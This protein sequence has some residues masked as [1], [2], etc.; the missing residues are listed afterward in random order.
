VNQFTSSTNDGKH[1]DHSCW[2]WHMLGPLK[3]N[4]TIYDQLLRDITA[5]LTAT[6][7]V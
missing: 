1:V 5:V 2:Y 7:Q 3:V 6:K 4:T